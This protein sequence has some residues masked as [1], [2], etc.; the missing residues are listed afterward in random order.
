M[1]WK[2]VVLT[3]SDPDGLGVPHPFLPAPLP[4]SPPSSS[5]PTSHRALQLIHRDWMTSQ[6]HHLKN[7]LVH[8]YVFP[9]DFWHNVDIHQLRILQF[10]KKAHQKQYLFYLTSDVEHL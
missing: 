10:T 5:S 8:T 2:M 1:V 3:L 9:L 7:S 4:P 6:L